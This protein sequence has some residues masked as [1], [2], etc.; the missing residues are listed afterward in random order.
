MEKVMNI[1]QLYPTGRVKRFHT[2][3]LAPQTIASHSWAVALIV[4]TIYPKNIAVPAKL[5]LAALTHD[6][7]EHVTGDIHSPAMKLCP[8]LGMVLA[9][10]ER[11]YNTEAGIEYELTD[12]ERHIL[13]WADVL[14]CALYAEHQE[15]MGVLQGHIIKLRAQA[16]L[17]DM[18][19]PTSEAKDLY[20]DIFGE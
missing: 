16:Y 12:R 17:K 7:A 10:M 19:F 15:N 9:G 13:K 14:E 11:K 8:E 2:T 5:L 18:S 4:A 3:D 1:S 6:C 20:D